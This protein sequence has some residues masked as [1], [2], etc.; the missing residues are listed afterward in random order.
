M[1]QGW[2]LQIESDAIAWLIID[3]PGKLNVLSS[4][5]MMRLNACLD[6]IAPAARNGRIKALIIRSGKEGSFIAGADISEIEAIRDAADGS[7][8]AKLGQSVFARI[9]SLGIPTIA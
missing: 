3:T 9:A 8:K 1:S 5:V 2:T 6:E 7:S 4:E